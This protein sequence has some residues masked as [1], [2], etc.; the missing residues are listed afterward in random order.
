ML[1]CASCGFENNILA[2]KQKPEFI[3]FNCGGD[4][5]KALDLYDNPPAEEDNLDNKEK[6]QPEKKS[7][8]VSN[9][10]S[11][12]KLFERS[13]HKKC[14]FCAEKIKAEAIRC[15]YCQ[16]DIP[17][18][19]AELEESKTSTTS[20][21]AN[22]NLF[23]KFGEWINSSP[24]GF[25]V[26]LVS[27]LFLPLAA[28][29][30]IMMD[31]GVGYSILYGFPLRVLIVTVVCLMLFAVKRRRETTREI[32]SLYFI[33]I[34]VEQLLSDLVMAVYFSTGGGKGEVADLIF[35]DLIIFAP[36]FIA[37]LLFVSI[38]WEKLKSGFLTVAAI[39]LS[40]DFLIAVTNVFT[41]DLERVYNR[42]DGGLILLLAN[43]EVAIFIKALALFLVYGSVSKRVKM[44]GNKDVSS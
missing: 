43:I 38:R 8:K 12:P 4:L 34:I 2:R 30:V 39:V 33:M 6:P 27:L 22:T 24:Q 11:S 40:L 41:T 44:N 9:Q 14:P 32:I 31:G 37:S 17:L 29:A 21:N 23:D 19:D 15:R 18:A 28:I 20:E 1:P 25:A 5:Q 16:S 35:F 10:L 13:G 3:C 36:L 42:I 7:A 26:L